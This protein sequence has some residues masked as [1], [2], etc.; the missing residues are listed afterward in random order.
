[1]QGQLQEPRAENWRALKG[2]AS[3][4]RLCVETGSGA[5]GGGRGQRNAAGRRCSWSEGS[6]GRS[7]VIALL[8]GAVV[9]L[10]EP[11]YIF[12]F[13]L[14]FHYLL[15][16]VG[17]AR[18][19]MP[20]LHYHSLLHQSLFLPDFRP[21]LG[22]ASGAVPY[23]WAYP[24]SD[25]P[26]EALGTGLARLIGCFLVWGLRSQQHTIQTEILDRA[27]VELELELLREISRAVASLAGGPRDIVAPGVLRAASEKRVWSSAGMKGRGKRETPRKPVDQ[28]HR[29]SQFPH[30][31]IRGDPAG[32]RTWIALVGGEPA[33]R[34]ATVAPSLHEAEE[35]PGSRTLAGLQKSVNRLYCIDVMERHWNEG[36]GGNGRSPRKPR[37]PTASSGTIPT[38]ENPVN[39]AGDRA[40]FAL[41]GGERIDWEQEQV[42]AVAEKYR[43]SSSLALSSADGMHDEVLTKKVTCHGLVKEVAPYG[44][45]RPCIEATVTERLALLASQQGDPGSIPGRLTPDFRVWESCRTMP[46]IGGF[47]RGSPVSPAPS[48]RRCSIFTSITLIGSED[49]DVKSRPNLFTALAPPNMERRRNEGVGETGGPREN[50]SANGI[51]RHDSHLRKPGDPARD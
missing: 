10:G 19:G 32:D 2:T 3:S 16:L 15:A 34:S 45:A 12:M 13:L 38:C 51:V 29:P 8:G 37:Q 33:N 40:R 7:S 36:G 49:L 17:H 4:F 1:M 31:K 23:T 48:F 43:F 14:T 5:E 28:R 11:S 21:S 50:P 20:Q 47:S 30:A 22:R 18:C 9:S 35:Y 25:W 26:H 46:L 6:R 42:R 24:F 27:R 39:P 41:V 44:R